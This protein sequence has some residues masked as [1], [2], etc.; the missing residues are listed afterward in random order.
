MPDNL[1][2]NGSFE[3]GQVHGPLLWWT[4]EG[5]HS[6]E[7]IDEIAVPAGWTLWWREGFPEPGDAS[8]KVARP[9]AE[10]ISLAAGF[11]DPKRIKAGDRAYKIVTFYAVHDCGL[12]QRVKVEAGKDYCFNIFA[13]SW[14]TNCSTRPHSPPY[15]ETCK[16]RLTQSHDWHWVGIDPTG[17]EDPNGAGVVWCDAV[18]IYSNYA[19]YPYAL[20]VRATAE[21]DHITVFTRATSNYALKHEDVYLDEA[22]LCEVEA[23]GPQRGAPRIQYHR[24]YVLLP[25]GAGAEWAQAVVEASWDVH[26]FTVGGSADDAGIGDLDYR[27]VIAVNAIGWGDLASFYQKHYPDIQYEVVGADTPDEL[28]EVL[29]ECY[30]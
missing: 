15:D 4:P 13:H 17:G 8:R 6:A 27:R 22:V 14:Y 26:R 9:K 28:V 2:Y 10:V 18:E 25:P 23:A 20:T 12:M 7:A 24:T 11:P 19:E 29:R 16:V 30:G 1:L 3:E 5:K 21:A